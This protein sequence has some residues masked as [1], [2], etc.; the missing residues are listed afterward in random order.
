MKIKHVAQVNH[1]W[2]S[3][4]LG[5]DGIDAV[6]IVRLNDGGKALAVSF[7]ALPEFVT[8]HAMDEGEARAFRDEMR[9]AIEVSDDL[10]GD[11]ALMLKRAM[12]GGKAGEV[13]LDE[14]ASIALGR[15]YRS[16]PVHPA[17]LKALEA[18]QTA[19]SAS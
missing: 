8:L 3:G 19:A 15:L 10:E 16:R 5:T 14:P 6:A 9:L 12:R 18:A 4:D 13:M 1:L 2:T 11:V 17:L 7:G